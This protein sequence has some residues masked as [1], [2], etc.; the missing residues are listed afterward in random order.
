MPRKPRS[1]RARSLYRQVR[2]TITDSNDGSWLV[3]LAWKDRNQDWTQGDLL[4]QWWVGDQGRILTPEDAV[5]A[6][7]E[8]LAAR[9]TLS[10]PD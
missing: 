7:V 3:T 10:L 2:L 6:A 5:R 1:V 8:T 9:H 4:D